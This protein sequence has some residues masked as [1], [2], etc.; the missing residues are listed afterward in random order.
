LQT[1]LG[2]TAVSGNAPAVAE[3]GTQVVTTIENINP[4]SEAVKAVQAPQARPGYVQQR[5]VTS[6]GSFLNG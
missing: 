2:Y 6:G 4:L 3:A 1:L 5:P